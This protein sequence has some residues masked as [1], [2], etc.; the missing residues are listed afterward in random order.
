MDH[1]SP[2]L[3]LKKAWL[4]PTLTLIW[5]YNY[6]VRGRQEQVKIPLSS[7]INDTNF[8]ALSDH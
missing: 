1:S 4:P 8:A 3:K 6:T 5:I 2:P 7:L